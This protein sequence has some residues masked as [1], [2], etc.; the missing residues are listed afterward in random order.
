MDIFAHLAGAFALL[1]LLVHVATSLTASRRC[2]VPTHRV[3]AFTHGPPVTVIRP[4][5]GMD[6]YEEPTLRS[7]FELDYAGFEVLFCCA[8]A[9]DPVVRLVQRLIAQYPSVQARLLIGD[10][11]ASQNPKLNNVAKGWR[12]ARHEWIVIAD[13][14]VLMPPDYL[15]RLLA[16][17]RHDTGLV[18]APPI[19][20]RPGSVWAELECAYLNTYQARWQYAADSLGMGFAQGKTMLWRR[21]DLEAAGGIWALASE[22]AEDAA[23]TKAV[24]AAGLRVSL[25]AGA[26]L[27]PLGHRSAPQ[28]WA[29]QA[30]W[31][32]LRRVTFP[33]FFALEILSGL[34]APLLC[35]VFA[36][37]MLGLDVALLAAAYAGL[38]LAAEAWLAT[39]VGWHY[40]WRSPLTWLLREL[41]LPALWINAWFGSSLS[42]RGSTLNVAREGWAARASRS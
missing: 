38:W 2:R 39:A 26:F 33:A 1:A 32:R 12:A 19:G 21:S 4:V 34:A 42:W 15:Q 17:W 10:E 13:S 7:T 31:A 41:L 40:S 5:C 11:R 29:R 24:R 8:S 35:L 27:Q 37:A 23:A 18:S 22:A 14:N 9:E 20:C 30:R 28:V 36:A 3:P 6:A 16:S 25:A